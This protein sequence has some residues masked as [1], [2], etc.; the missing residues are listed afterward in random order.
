MSDLVLDD[1]DFSAAAAAET[2]DERLAAQAVGLAREL[3]TTSLAGATRSERRRQARLGS[4]L[5]DP[6]GREMIF[7]LTDQVMRIDSPA[8]AA[9]KFADVIER[10]PTTAI[11]PLDR[12]MMRAGAIVAPLLPKIVMPIVVKRIKHET[13]GIVLPA[14]D[15]AF[16]N[17]VK[18]R[19]GDGVRLN[20]NPLGEAILS[21]A[22]ADE[23]MR[24]VIERIE[25]PDVTYV[26]VKV[27]AIV[28]NLDAL[29][30]DH[31]VERICERLRTLY[32]R[33]SA[34]TPTTF[35]NLDMEEYR[36]LELTLQS[37]MRVLD[38]P[39]FR[40][41]DAGIVLQAYLPDSHDALQRL[42][43]WAATRRERGGGHIKVRLVKG[44]NLAM[45]HAEAEI[46]GWTAAPYPTKAD[47]DA[48][49]KAMLDSA[50]RDEWSDALRIGLASHNLF[51]IAWA[52]VIGRE[53]GA[54]DRIEFEML[55]GM[56]PSQARSVEELAGGLLMYAPVVADDDFDASIAYLTR[57]LDENTQ[58]ENFL[59]SLFTLV[60]DS[61]LFDQEV[62]R[63]RAAVE[64]RHTVSRSRRRSPNL[65]ISIRDGNNQVGFANEAESDFT[66]GVTRAAIAAAVAAP[67]TP[68]FDRI[69][70]EQQIDEIVSAAVAAFALDD[71]DADTRR[72]W[73]LG[74][75]DLMATERFQT[76]GLL[77]HA[78]SKT[79]HEADPEIAEAIDFCRYYATDGRAA[80]DAARAD[81]FDVSGRGVITVIG[82]WNFPYAIPTGGVA[83]AIAAGNSV[84]LKPAP[85][86]VEVGAWIA[87]QFWRAGVPRD[88][89]QLVVCDDGPVGTRLVTHDD[90][91]TV[92][93]TGAYDTAATFLGWKPSM[94][95]FAETSGKDALIITPSADL[96]QA[97]ADLV[98]SAFGHAGQKCS[99]ASLGIVVGELY[100]DPSFRQRL[101]D[102]V[103]SLRVGPAT[104]PAS[105]MGPLVQRPNE[106]LERALTR[107][108]RGES[109]LVEPTCLD[110]DE[111]GR[112]WTPG[113]RL[114]VTEGS[115]FHRTECF[116]P[117]LGIMRA[118]DLDHALRL[119]NATAFG[120]TGGIHSL[121][122]AE[123]DHWLEHVEI[124][125]AYIN[126]H[127][128]GA[129]VQRQPFGGWK[130]SVVGGGAKAGGPGYVAQFAR[131]SGGDS[132][133]G[134]ARR[135]FESAWSD[136]FS[137]PTDAS[138]LSVE[139]NVL[140]HRPLDRVAVRHDGSDDAS[141]ALLRLAAQIAGVEL[142]ESNVDAESDGDFARRAA[143][144]GVD[145]VRLVTSLDDA[146]RRILHDVNIAV[147][148][149]PP[150][151]NGHLELQHWV[152]EQS[153]S[154]TMHRHGR[155]LR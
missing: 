58:P 72:S 135:S 68:T 131:V 124:G 5:D 22:E 114:G 53:R 19:S 64:A 152:R 52:F 9:A 154:R 27:S 145:R 132:T 97:I 4:L 15:P 31:S 45:E 13:R 1:A 101:R 102:A 84:I 107:L 113:V 127:I 92:V 50:L 55:E 46:H 48:S 41:L 24:A 115:W 112:L 105:M 109:W 93:L 106:P 137:T 129:I 140:R 94:R 56:A 71:A 139:S 35:V 108:D 7:A 36:D 141:L 21:D 54:L 63:F 62:A 86:A 111:D 79:A 3:L 82:P 96:D 95:L 75:A 120:L 38:E 34:A 110:P 30:F 12:L 100:D 51:D 76:V 77:A 67:P 117:V 103:A 57:R 126:R 104:D 121:D 87:E 20:V 43:T 78:V 65:V 142:V 122:D 88:V 144:S 74:V 8:R 25:R 39:E 6:N 80:L 33:A 130:R 81:G 116:G 149:T 89:L 2:D 83:A 60:P 123:I 17:H 66:D 29:A 125:N 70:S 42:G 90:V 69:E 11:G 153:I 47:V 146:A 155:L 61:P 14:D 32:R 40:S 73:L 23:R 151:S 16:A 134:A 128:T 44:A 18:R 59:R 26:S 147:D 28:A 118:D 138:G 150:V 143:R 99:A 37:F 98:R 91:D 10:H 85:E 49:Y 148:E 133:L 136:T 119:Q